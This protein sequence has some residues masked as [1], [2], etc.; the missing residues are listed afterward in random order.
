MESNNRIPS[1]ETSFLSQWTGGLFVQYGSPADGVGSNGHSSTP[2][3]AVCP[4]SPVLNEP[5]V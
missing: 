2:N 1:A 3:S 5:I 4:S